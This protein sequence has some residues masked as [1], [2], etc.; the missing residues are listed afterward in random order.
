MPRLATCQRRAA[1]R[2]GCLR[3]GG[4]DQGHVSLV[5]AGPGAEDL[6]TLRAQRLLMEADAIVYDA[7]V[8]EAVV[9][10]GRRDAERLAGRQTQGLPFQE[11]KGDRRAAGVAWPSKASAWCG[12]SPAIRWYSAAPAKSWQRCAMRA[13][14]HEVVPGV[15]SAF[16][17]AADFALPLTLRGTASSL[18]FTTGHDLKGDAL[19]DWA[20]A[21][22]R[23]RNSCRLYGPHRCCRCCLAADRGGPVHLTRRLLRSKMPAALMRACSTAR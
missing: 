12:S 6:L 13:F 15:T 11:P 9:A 5:G 20:Q 22:D 8:P 14:R 18:V 4:I 17:A 10:M 1:Q 7:L 19:P 21:C 16:A 2:P 3:A 23:R